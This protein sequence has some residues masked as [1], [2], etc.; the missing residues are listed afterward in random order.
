MYC[1]NSALIVGLYHECKYCSMFKIYGDIMLDRWVLGTADN[2][3]PEAPVPV[4]LESNIKFNAGGAANLAINLIGIG[5]TVELYGSVGADDEGYQLVKLIAQQ[6]VKTNILFDG[7]ITTTKTRL[8]GQRGQH[9]VRWDREK[10]YHGRLGEKFLDNLKTDDVILISDYD[11][12]TVSRTLIESVLTITKNVYV[13]PKQSADVYHG[14]YLVKPNMK[15]YNEWFGAFTVESAAKKVAQYDW[16]WLIVTD[17]GNGVHVIGRNEYHHYKEQAREV[18]D[19]TGAGDT[20]LSV[21]SHLHDNKKMSVPHACEI[22][23]YASARTVEKRGVVP[24]SKQDLN[25]GIVW[26]NGV[27]DILHTGHLKLLRYAKSLGRKLVVGI[28]DD[29]SVKRIKGKDRPIN[30]VNER[31]ETLLNLGFVDEVVVF[32]TDTPLEEIKKVR[33]DIIVKGSDYTVET[34]V[35][36]ELAE[37]KI[38]PLIEGH[39]TSK[40]IE[41]M[42]N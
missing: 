26:T 12:G 23:C 14:C 34:T 42:K 24:V 40:I 13:D 19:V 5:N 6:G 16:Q 22:A 8:V 18:A 25:R 15:R 1:I 41:R 27:F 36:H 33:P 4:L 31:K 2:M 38:F 11:K 21:L 29:E 17:G 7:E 39:S 20:F 28:N 35:G 3:S 32:N 37:V 9:I 30:S 10:K